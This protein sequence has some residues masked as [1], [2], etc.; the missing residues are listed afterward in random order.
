MVSALNKQDDIDLDYYRKLVDGAVETI[1]EFGS[2]EEFVTC[3]IPPYERML[4][5]I[6]SDELPF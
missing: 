1:E 3:D 6:Q 4:P 5:S 2:F